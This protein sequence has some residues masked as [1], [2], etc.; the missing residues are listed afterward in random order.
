MAGFTKLLT[1]VDEFNLGERALLHALTV[2]A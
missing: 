2:P 1:H